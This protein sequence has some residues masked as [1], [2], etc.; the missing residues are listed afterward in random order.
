[1]A[2]LRQP[3][4]GALIVL[5]WVGVC[6]RAYGSA[7]PYTEERPKKLIVQ[8]VSRVLA[9]QPM[10]SGLWVN[11]FDYRRLSDLKNLGV[12]RFAQAQPWPGCEGG[13]A[14][15][16][17]C[18]MPWYFPLRDVIRGSWY[19]DFPPFLPPANAEFSLMLAG[20]P[21]GS[22][23]T[24]RVTLALG[25]PSHMAVVFRDPGKRIRAWS[26]AQDVGH[27]GGRRRSD[28]HIFVFYSSGGTPVEVSCDASLM[29]WC[30][31]WGH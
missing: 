18:D 11:G 26:L 6:F 1:M 22:D 16:G 8:H 9:G 12:E 27:N 31:H 13:V 28:G 2:S 19:L 17:Y 14:T 30:V 15:T 10:D 4:A 29:I 20:S 24:R 3:R 25:G 23:G 7:Y 5:V 21:G